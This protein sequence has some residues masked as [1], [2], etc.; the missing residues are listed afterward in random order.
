MPANR[1]I[2]LP[3]LSPV[4]A[5]NAIGHHLFRGRWQLVY[6]P[7]Q[8]LLH[9]PAATRELNAGRYTDAHREAIGDPS[10]GEYEM[11]QSRAYRTHKVMQVLRNILEWGKAEA[12]VLNDR[13]EWLSASPGD[14]SE[15]EPYYNLICTELADVIKSNK[16]SSGKIRIQ[17]AELQAY[18]SY[19]P[20]VAIGDQPPLGT[21]KRVG[22]RPFNW[23]AL[24][25]ELAK[26]QEAG[27]IAEFE[28]G[29]KAR[30]CNSLHDWYL[31]KV[32]KKEAPKSRSIM[33]KLQPELELIAESARD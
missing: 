25:E 16:S 1:E 8:R 20:P 4:E 6:A 9:P 21:P 13:G 14:W 11:R 28:R 3:T 31:D 30:E 26:R 18:L 29:W 32:S 10:D 23:G 22:R 24:R 17:R 12:W 7:D 19:E 5:Y 33:K 2:D 27:K 15:G